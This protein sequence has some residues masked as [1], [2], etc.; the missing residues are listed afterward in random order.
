MINEKIT[1]DKN[2]ENLDLP[3]YSCQKTWHP[4]NECPFLH[5]IPDHEKIINKNNY[6]K[7]N[8]R[9]KFNRNKK[10]LSHLNTLKF[11][12]VLEQHSKK[13]Q[14]S[15]ENYW[16][17]SI[18]TNKEMTAMEESSYNLEE[19]SI[20]EYEEPDSPNL[21]EIVSEKTR[22]SSVIDSEPKEILSPTLLTRLNNN[23]K[24]NQELE[25]QKKDSK[26]SIDL[27]RKEEI[28]R[29]IMVKKETQNL[30]QNDFNLKKKVVIPDFFDFNFESPL[31]CKKFYPEFNF[32]P[33]IMK[34]KKYLRNLQR[35]KLKSLKFP[36]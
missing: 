25:E 34:F 33:S 36:K 30:S 6:S 19:E 3:C 29:K 22:K 9:K 14:S 7:P 32:K 10:I 21:R 31:D 11:K 8:E 28:K 26:E 13:F 5:Y 27:E 12:K 15:F 24:S 18:K 16:R 23:Q 4:F 20:S 17:Y 2:Y 35:K 1:Q